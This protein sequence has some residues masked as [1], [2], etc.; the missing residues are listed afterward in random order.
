MKVNYRR[1][2]SHIFAKVCGVGMAIVIVYLICLFDK[3]PVLRFFHHTKS[4]LVKML[5]KVLTGGILREFIVGKFCSLRIHTKSLLS[6][7]LIKFWQTQ[8]L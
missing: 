7:L 5:S 2:H 6:T 8:V 1:V 3:N 4:A